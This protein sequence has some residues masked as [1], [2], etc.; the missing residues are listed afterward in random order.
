MEYNEFISLIE[1]ELTKIK[2]D[3]EVV[4]VKQITRNNGIE[5]DS[6][7]VR[8]INKNIAPVI[9][10][11]DFYRSDI[12]ES[13]IGV[14]A[15]KIY[16]ILKENALV[17]S[18][19]TGWLMDY[20]KVKPKLY[21]RLINHEKNYK[22]LKSVPYDFFLDLAV[23]P[24]IDV[25]DICCD[26][27]TVI[28][29][30]ELLRVWGVD[31]DKVLDD[32]DENTNNEGV[33][34]ISFSKMVLGI[35]LRPGDDIAPDKIMNENP[36]VGA[37]VWTN[38]RTLYGAVGMLYEDE[39]KKFCK[40]YKSNAIIIPSSVHEII[41]IPARDSSQIEMISEMIEEVNREE[42]PESEFLSNTAYYYERKTG[43][44]HMYLNFHYDSPE[45]AEKNEAYVNELYEEFT[46]KKIPNFN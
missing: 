37:E 14:L 13:E 28:V 17:D 40:R 4:E 43:D 29:T 16:T 27:S 1:D 11:K 32:A 45:D 34:I 6:I 33:K 31:A 12:K 39:L 18:I 41:V 26:H 46:G 44:Y 24:Y 19:D 5:V 15:D 22:F 23:C 35:D 2:L 36:I 10:A 21:L 20:E 25:G 30:N 42:L 38:K 9:Y 8:D 7:T 3:T